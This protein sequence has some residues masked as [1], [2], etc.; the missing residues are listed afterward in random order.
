LAQ[1]TADAQA[2]LAGLSGTQSELKRREWNRLNAR[3]SR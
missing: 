3:K 1:E 2:T